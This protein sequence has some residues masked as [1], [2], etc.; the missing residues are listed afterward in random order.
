MRILKT[1]KSSLINSKNTVRLQMWEV[2]GAALT[3]K[4]VTTLPNLGTVILFYRL[5][6]PKVRPLID[7]LERLVTANEEQSEEIDGFSDSWLTVSLIHDINLESSENEITDTFFSFETSTD[8]SSSGAVLSLAA[9]AELSEFLR[10]FQ[11]ATDGKRL[12]GR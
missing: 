10:E 3:F 1:I 8:F 5:P 4:I 6:L 2:K 7:A 11:T 9:V 12:L